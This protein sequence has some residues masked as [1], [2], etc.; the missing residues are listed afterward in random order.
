MRY[1]S[2]ANTWFAAT[3][4]DTF[5]GDVAGDSRDGGTFDA[6]LLTKAKIQIRYARFRTRGCLVG[7][8]RAAKAGVSGWLERFCFRQRA[9]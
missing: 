8:P 2:A 1:S 3:R 7:L 9:K 4:E 5:P 6:R